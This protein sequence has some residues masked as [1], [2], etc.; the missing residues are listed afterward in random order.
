MGA[1]TLAQ[2]LDGLRYRTAKPSDATIVAELVAAGFATYRDF[3]PP[4]WQPRS[5]AQDEGAIHE[6]LSRGDTHARL[7]L[8]G[9][10]LVGLTGWM[11]A[12]THPPDR[13]RIP[14]RAHLWLLFVTQRY[15]ASG[16]A[17]A[18]LAWSTATMGDTGHTSA[19]LWTPRD[20][21]RA[22]A[23]YEREGWS[24][25]GAAVFNAD[26]ALDVVLYE[27]AL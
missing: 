25:S 13:R 1:V 21:A 15:W 9:S 22:R 8:H 26:L 19:Q 24:T 23:F 11:P 16:L 4:G 7:A 2:M 20:S 3:A 5:A 10:T 14:D 17:Q 6:R 18:L 27:R 12:L